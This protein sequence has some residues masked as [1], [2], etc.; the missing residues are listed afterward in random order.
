MN[1][2]VRG[3]QEKIPSDTVRGEFEKVSVQYG[4]V[5]V[6]HSAGEELFP[7]SDGIRLF[8]GTPKELKQIMNTVRR[9]VT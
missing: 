5:C 3:G 4:Y 9:A 6:Q 2:Y 8:F 1:R 7:E